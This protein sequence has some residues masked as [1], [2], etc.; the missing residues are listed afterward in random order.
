MCDQTHECRVGRMCRP[1]P[2]EVKWIS[3]FCYVICETT[4][5]SHRSL[6]HRCFAPN[7]VYG[8]QVS[9]SDAISAQQ[10]S[11]SAIIHG[12][13]DRSRDLESKGHTAVVISTAFWRTMSN[14]A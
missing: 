5:I 3:F 9:G 4:R 12:P 6:V 1:R 10:L 2:L 13:G 14:V 8:G 11:A 7:D